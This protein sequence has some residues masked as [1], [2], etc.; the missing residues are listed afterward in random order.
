MGADCGSSKRRILRMPIA[1]LSYLFSTN[2]YSPL[3]M[4]SASSLML[5]LQLCCCII[6]MFLPLKIIT[7]RVPGQ[8]LLAYYF[9]LSHNDLDKFDSYYS[10]D[11][12]ITRGGKRG[13]G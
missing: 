4:H 8:G 13:R 3:R 9:S 7:I 6:V 10:M 11:G 1:S 2:Y 5:P 12:G